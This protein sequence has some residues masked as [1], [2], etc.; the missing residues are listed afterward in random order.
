[1][2]LTTPDQ[3]YYVILQLGSQYQVPIAEFVNQWNISNS[4]PIS[5]LLGCNIFFPIL[6]NGV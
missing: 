2:I 1:M 5:F 4:L 3:F 6:P